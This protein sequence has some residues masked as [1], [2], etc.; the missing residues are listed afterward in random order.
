[1]IPLL[2]DVQNRQI[3]RGR[4][5][6]G[7]EVMGSNYLMGTGFPSGVM[8]MFWDEIVMLVAQHWDGS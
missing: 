2:C 3:H 8:N 5:E 1:M 4:K 6:L 7:E